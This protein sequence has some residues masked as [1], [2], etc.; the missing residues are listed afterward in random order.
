[1]LY[2]LLC[3]SSDLSSSDLLFSIGSLG[4]WFWVQYY[5][6]EK[7][8]LVFPRANFVKH[9]LDNWIVVLVIQHL[10]SIHKA[11][12]WVL[13][14][15]LQGIDKVVNPNPIT[16]QESGLQESLYSLIPLQ[17]HACIPI[18]QPVSTSFSAEPPKLEQT[19]LVQNLNFCTL[20][21][22]LVL[23]LSNYEFIS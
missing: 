8:V 22:S 18:W 21:Q 14:Y 11:I 12:L 23:Q 9:L 20:K 5:W 1:M 10:I 13:S 3:S 6:N 19:L 15:I 16:G 7:V 4:L 17:F 2:I